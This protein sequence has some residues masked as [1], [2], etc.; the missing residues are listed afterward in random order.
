MHPLHA[1]Y[2]MAAAAAQQQMQ[3]QQ[4]QMQQQMQRAGAMR[5]IVPAAVPAA[6]AAAYARSVAQPVAAQ[7][8][9]PAEDGPAVLELK[10]FL[11]DAP[12]LWAHQAGEPPVRK[13]K[14]ANGEE[15]S[16]VLWKG[17]FFITGTDVVK[18][19]AFRFGA[20]GRSIMNPKKFEE[21]VFSDL[22]NLKP[23][24]DA[25]L[26]EPR[27]EFLEF[28]HRN[29]CIRTQKKQKVFFWDKVPHDTLFQEAMERNYKRATSM[30]S[31]AN[32]MAVPELLKQYVMLNSAMGGAQPYAHSQLLPPAGAQQFVP[33]RP[34]P[35]APAAKRPSLSFTPA[36]RT[37]E[38][39]FS[40]PRAQSEGSVAALAA[41]RPADEPVELDDFGYAYLELGAEL[42]SPA[43]I[44]P[45]APVCG[46]LDTANLFGGCPAADEMLALPPSPLIVD[47]HIAVGA[48]D[49]PGASSLTASDLFWEKAPLTP[50]GDDPMGS[51]GGVSNAIE[52]RNGT[53]GLPWANLWA[54]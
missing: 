46:T 45:E 48:S 20:A 1:H 13:Y 38:P 42:R 9:L 25:V 12:K 52:G 31:I 3:H 18:V 22:R 23:G 5:P 7:A 34:Q 27:S 43:A 37:F 28:L 4:I 35:E 49:A 50:L 21:G 6:A 30:L 26:E 54:D 8:G 39:G 17:R 15:I 11:A 51:F 33:A 44:E 10:R 40:L 2:A 16:C 47:P 32:M 53:V 41:K 29:G 19:L 14:M 24:L 36:Q